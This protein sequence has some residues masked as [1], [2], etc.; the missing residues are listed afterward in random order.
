MANRTRKRQLT[1]IPY[2]MIDTG[3]MYPQLVINDHIHT[4]HRSNESNNV[5]RCHKRCGTKIYMPFG[6]NA[7][8]II[9]TWHTGHDADK[10]AVE[11]LRARVGFL[12]LIYRV[13]CRI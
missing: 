6:E 4:F 12:F 8:P 13:F 1:R 9:D 10:E 5:Y 3:R 7:E 2:E 11:K